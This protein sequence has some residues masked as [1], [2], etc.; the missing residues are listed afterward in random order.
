MYGIGSLFSPIVHFAG[1]HRFVDLIG[2]L[3]ESE[4]CDQNSKIDQFLSLRDGH[5]NLCGVVIEHLSYHI[6]A[7][8]ARL[9][10]LES[11]QIAI[12]CNSYHS[13]H[14]HLVF[15]RYLLTNV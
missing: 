5:K 11:I 7:P 3:T 9:L 8:H 4:Y 12:K 13:K 14:C 2:I 15:K 1:V 10:V 6:H